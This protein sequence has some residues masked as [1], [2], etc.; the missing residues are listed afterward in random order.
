[1]CGLA[2]TDTFFLFLD[3]VQWQAQLGRGNE[4]HNEC[5][6]DTVNP[7]AE[8]NLTS[9]HGRQLL[10][11]TVS[12][13]LIFLVGKKREQPSNPGESHR[14]TVHKLRTLML[15]RQGINRMAYHVLEKKQNGIA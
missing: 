4:M 10:S 14:V 2:R 9:N 11:A 13:Y 12:F 8:L 7:F 15:G 3:A 1:V 6:N 5:I